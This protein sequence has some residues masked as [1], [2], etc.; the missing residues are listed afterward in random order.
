M[1]IYRW[2]T[3]LDAEYR[4]HPYSL[5]MAHRVCESH[6]RTPLGQVYIPDALWQIRI[7]TANFVNAT[8][9]SFLNCRRKTRMYLRTSLTYFG[10]EAYFVKEA[11]Q[12]RIAIAAYGSAVTIFCSGY[13]LVG[14]N[15]APRYSSGF[16]K[17]SGRRVLK[18]QVVPTVIPRPKWV[19]VPAR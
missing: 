16:R 7:E 19:F 12:N 3:S 9:G 14:R 1:L 18:F 4:R 8:F 10:N 5:S 13:S 15:T 6:E 2:I 11:G 17:G